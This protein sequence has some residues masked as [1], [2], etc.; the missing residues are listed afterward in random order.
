MA[1]PRPRPLYSMLMLSM[2]RCRHSEKTRHHRCQLRHRRDDVQFPP[3]QNTDY[4]LSVLG[5]IQ[6]HHILMLNISLGA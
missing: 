2:Q 6:C 4:T 5:I 1:V 3:R